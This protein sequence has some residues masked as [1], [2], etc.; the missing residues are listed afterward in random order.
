MP[1]LFFPL[2]VTSLPHNGRA[3][4]I[5]DA[6]PRHARVEIVCHTVPPLIIGPVRENGLS[7][8]GH[9]NSVAEAQVRVAAG[10]C[11]PNAF[12]SF[13]IFRNNVI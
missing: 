2:R 4:W 1:G 8:N 9:A 11:G 3:N 10:S 5:G 12:A 7:K 6:L 13:V